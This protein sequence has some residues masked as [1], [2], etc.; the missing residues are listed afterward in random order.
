MLV[1]CLGLDLK[2][3]IFGLGLASSGFGLALGLGM[4]GLVKKRGLIIMLY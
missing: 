4:A 3:E 2:A 1:L